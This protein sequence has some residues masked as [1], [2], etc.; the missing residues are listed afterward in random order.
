MANRSYRLTRR[1]DRKLEEI[2][3]YTRDHFGLEQADAYHESFI[4]AFELLTKFSSM[5]PRA[6]EIKVGL[7]KYRHQSHF[8]FYSRDDEGII[9][10]DIRHVRTDPRKHM[11]QD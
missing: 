3:I 11:L 2:Y 6:D 4:Q 10:E 5:G 1:V 8:I 7:R 9:V